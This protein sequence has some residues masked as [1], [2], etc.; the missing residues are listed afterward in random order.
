MA[1]T[2]SVRTTAEGS[3]GLVE[4]IW[5]GTKGERVIEFSFPSPTLVCCNADLGGL[6]QSRGSDST[7][8]AVV[9]NIYT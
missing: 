1:T 5:R 8:N 7:R 2:S 3:R 4:L 6:L 9:V